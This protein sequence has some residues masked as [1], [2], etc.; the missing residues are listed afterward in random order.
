MRPLTEE[1]EKNWMIARII[2]V[3]MGLAAPALYLVIALSI[4]P[5][6]GDFDLPAGGHSA[7]VF[8]MLLTLAIVDPLLV[9]VIER[10]QLNTWRRM[11]GSR[12]A[13]RMYLSLVVLRLAFVEASFLFGLVVYLLTYDFLRLLLFY[14]VGLIWLAVFWPRR[15]KYEQFVQTGEVR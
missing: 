7:L 9:P 10:A 13:D 1:Q 11:K 4:R 2:A 6:R 12:S 5:D 3:A 8:F 15:E 14:L